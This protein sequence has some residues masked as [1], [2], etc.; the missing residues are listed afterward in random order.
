MTTQEF[1]AAFAIAKQSHD[2]PPEDISMFDGFGLPDF[3]PVTVTLPQLASLIRWQAA[4]FNGS[5]DATALEE[6]RSC[7]RRRFVVAG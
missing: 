4:C 7:G 2:M 6:I 1:K 5:W 3:Q